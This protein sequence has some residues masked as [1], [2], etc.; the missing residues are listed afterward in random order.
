MNIMKKKLVTTS[1]ILFLVPTILFSMLYSVMRYTIYNAGEDYSQQIIGGWEGTQYLSSKQL[2][3]C[4]KHDSIVMFFDENSVEINGTLIKE[5]KYEYKW[6]TGSIAKV[7]IDGEKYI[8]VFSINSLGQL[9]VAINAMDYIITF[10][11][12]DA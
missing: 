11:R 4:D 1:L 5:G 10:N 7:D 8:F 9:K 6:D 3:P 12:V 2:H